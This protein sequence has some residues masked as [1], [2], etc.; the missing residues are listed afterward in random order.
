VAFPS[1][2]HKKA[3]HMA[4]NTGNAFRHHVRRAIGKRVLLLLFLL[5]LLF[6]SCWQL[7]VRF[8]QAPENEDS[9]WIVFNPPTPG[10]GTDFAVNSSI[11]ISAAISSAALDNV[12]WGWNGTNCTVYDSSLVLAYNFDNNT[13]IG[14]DASTVA[15]VSSYGGK[16][17]FLRKVRQRTVP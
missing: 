6:A 11:T 4:G 10:N 17:T 13:A 15:D 7:A 3:F 2:K 9:V 8:W 5:A 1:F 16:G 12:T 14:D